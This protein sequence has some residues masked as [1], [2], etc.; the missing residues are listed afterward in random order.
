MK[1]LLSLIAVWGCAWATF[2]G[3]A[4]SDPNIVFSPYN[5]YR[6]GSSYAQSPNPGA[7]VK[8]G[9]TGSSIAVNLDLSPLSSAHVP[10]AQYPVIRYSVDGGP[11]VTTHLAPNMNLLPCAKGLP[12]GNHTLLVQYVAGYVFLD[13]WTPVNLLRITGFT[14]DSGATT[15]T[16]SGPLAPRLAN[17]L[18]LGDSITNGDD[19]IATFKGGITNEVDTQDG[20][21]GY[22]AIVAAGL[23]AEY[24]VVAY[25]GASW[26]GTAAD[27]HTPGLM[28]TYSMLDR[29]HS[30]LVNGKFSP[31]P[32]HIFINM[33]ENYPPAEGDVPKLVSQLRAASGDQTKIWILVPFSGR[34]RNALKSGFEVYGRLAPKDAD[35]HLIDLGNCAYLTDTGPTMLSVDGQHPLATLHAL[36]AAQILQVIF[37]RR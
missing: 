12:P 20:T 33:G 27:Q 35:T 29:I 25:G 8:L 19:D 11:P 23:G 9:F 17:I 31:S 34:A 22:P 5:W 21:V 26:D 15:V 7:Y 37:A 32:D 10:A 30:R 28:A 3:V 6:D 24:G 36:L 4:V 14:L 2:A 16:P 18:F 13:F 1:R